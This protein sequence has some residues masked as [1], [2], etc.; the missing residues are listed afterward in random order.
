MQVDCER[1]RQLLDPYLDQELTAEEISAV[2][3]HLATCRRCAFE[4]TQMLRLK[5]IIG[6]WKGPSPS[7]DLHEKVMGKVREDMRRSGTP[8]ER[9]YRRVAL[10]VTGGALTV[11]GL[12]IL[13]F[14]VGFGTGGTATPDLGIG[15]AV[16]M[17]PAMPLETIARLEDLSGEG[18]QAIR[19]DGT[20]TKL[21]PPASLKPDDI[22][23][24]PEDATATVRVAGGR[25]IVGALAWQGKVPKKPPR[26]LTRMRFASPDAAYSLKRGTVRII[27]SG[28]GLGAIRIDT[29][30]GIAY[31]PWEKRHNE[32]TRAVIYVGE[33]SVAI[34]VVAGEAG[35]LKGSVEERENLPIRKDELLEIELKESRAEGQ[36]K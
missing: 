17:A 29:S 24:V 21:T 30:A 5:E 3:Q 20:I 31:V 1:I 15:E 13:V 16:A 9:Y 18:V 12:G 28:E 35:L 7:S 2:E 32:H 4:S 19:P 26:G 14:Y 10:A 25:L 27:A 34:G 23:E 33:G 22:L 8:L 36:A 11:L 6:R